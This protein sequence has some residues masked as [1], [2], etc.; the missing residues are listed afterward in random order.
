NQNPYHN[1]S[2]GMAELLA[3]AQRYNCLVTAAH[4][5]APRYFNL[6]QRITTCN[7]D[8]AVLTDIDAVEVCSGQSFRAMNERAMRLADSFGKSFVGGSDGHVMSAL[9]STVT[10]AKSTSVASFLNAIRK[11]RNFVVGWEMPLV[12]RLHPYSGMSLRYLRYPSTLPYYYRYHVREQ[13]DRVGP[14]FAAA[15][16]RMF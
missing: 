8:P 14:K 5:A 6:M 12:Q 7:V 11:Q 2:I 16:A 13:L 4:P 15:V 1:L 3:A 10:H 9:G